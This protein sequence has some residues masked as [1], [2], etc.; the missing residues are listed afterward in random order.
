MFDAVRDLPTSVVDL[1]TTEEGR[2]NARRRRIRRRHPPWRV[3]RARLIAVRVSRDQRTAIVGASRYFAS[4][5]K[6][7]LLRGLTRAAMH[8]FSARLHRRLSL[9]VR[10]GPQVSLRR[11]QRT[12]R[13][14]RGGHDSRRA[15]WRRTGVRVGRACL[16]PSPEWRTGSRAR[17]LMPTVCRLFSV[18]PKPAAAAGRTRGSHRDA[19]AVSDEPTGDSAWAPPVAGMYSVAARSPHR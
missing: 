2:M 5:A 16:S 1:T 14:R 15:R 6:P 11:R 19:S 8:Q 18:R 13:R 7:K 3:H 17:R 10:Q 12:R 4:H 9:G